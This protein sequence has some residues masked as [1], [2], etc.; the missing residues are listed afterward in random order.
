MG[1]I[2]SFLLTIVKI[3]LILAPVLLFIG[4][5]YAKYL[6]NIDKREA[7]YQRMYT[8]IQN[9]INAWNVYSEADENRIH[10]NF[11]TLFNLPYCDNEMS[12][13]LWSEFGIKRDYLEA[14]Q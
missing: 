5:L 7:E 1:T 11:V 4:L 8:A 9:D 6:K 10:D 3:A 14:K 13:V 12:H 2:T